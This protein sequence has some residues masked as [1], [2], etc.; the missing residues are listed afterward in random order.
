[1][2][3]VEQGEEDLATRKRNK[4]NVFRFSLYVSS[5]QYQH[6]RRPDGPDP[7][8]GFYNLRFEAN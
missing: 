5:S 2:A 4:D 8:L 7:L 3:P 6:A 1:M